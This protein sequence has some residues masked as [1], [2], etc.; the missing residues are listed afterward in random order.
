M[1]NSKQSEVKLVTFSQRKMNTQI[2]QT[3]GLLKKKRVCKRNTKAAGVVMMKTVKHLSIEN[4]FLNR[5][6]TETHNSE[7]KM[8]E[9]ITNKEEIVCVKKKIL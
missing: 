8:R 9:I 6:V 2:A 4:V 5:N 3:F 1:E 7:V